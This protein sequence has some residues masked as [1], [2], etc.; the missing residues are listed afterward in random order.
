MLNCFSTFKGRFRDGG[1]YHMPESYHVRRLYGLPTKTRSDFAVISETIAE[2]VGESMTAG[3]MLPKEA[4]LT[5]YE[6]VP[7]E[8]KASWHLLEGLCDIRYN[9]LLPLA[10]DQPGLVLAEYEDVSS[11]ASMMGKELHHVERARQIITVPYSRVLSNTDWNISIGQ[12]K[13]NGE[14]KA[15]IVEIAYLPYSD[16][17]PPPSVEVLVEKFASLAK[18]PDLGFQCF[19]SSNTD[20]YTRSGLKSRPN[21]EEFPYAHLALD[22]TLFAVA[23]CSQ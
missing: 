1:N 21:N 23:S 20:F 17:N 7:K 5:R 2:N 4:T 15:I 14:Q 10:A 8:G 18:L 13:A 11:L 16:T 6:C 19:R 12:V 3:G 9:M 22:L